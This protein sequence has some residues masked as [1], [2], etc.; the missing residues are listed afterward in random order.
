MIGLRVALLVALLLLPAVAT[1]SWVSSAGDR[2]AQLE[3]ESDGRAEVAIAAAA[4]EA[5]CTPSL[6][7][8][9]RRVLES[10]GLLGSGQGRGC[11]P[12]EARNVATMSG[13]DFNALFTPMKDRGGIIQF[14]VGKAG[15]DESARALVERLYAEKRGASYFFVVARASLDGSV[16]FNRDLSKQRAEA[17]MSHLHDTFQDPAIDRE[18]GLLWLGAEYAQLDSQFCEWERSGP[19]DACRAQDIN[20]SAFLAW[21]DCR[22]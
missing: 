15:L 12:I 14:E 13:D 21:I 10:C 20:R 22:L 9:L 3:A 4:D 19:Q 11:Q 6:R 17:V 8:I 5:Y 16:R 7:R 18:V 2:L 1:Y